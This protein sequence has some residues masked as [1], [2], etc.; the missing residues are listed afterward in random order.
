[1]FFNLAW[2]NSK[3]NR[4]ENLIYFL[5]MVTA[6]ATFYIVL[7]LGSQDVM[8]FLE[9]I[10]SDAVNRL[11]TML[12]PTVYLFS[13]LFVFFLVIFA[14]KYQ[15][16]CR[17]RELGLYLMFG[18]T[19]RHLF[20]Q[21]MAEGLITSLLALLGGLICG[22]FLS[23]VI[24]LATARLVGRGIIAHQSSF[25]VSAVLL[26][27]LGFLMI[28]VVALFILCGKLFNKEIHQ[29]LYGEM[30]KKQQVGKMSG[31]LFSLILGAVVL[32]LAYWVILKY[33]MV[34]GG[35]MII[36]AVILGI[37]GTMLFIRGLA[38]LLS[39]AAASVKRNTTH[40]LYIFTLRQLHENIVHKYIS[41]G[42]ASILI[43][44]T[45]MLIADGSTRI[46]SYGNQM[47]RGSSVYDFTVTGNE[48]TVEKYLSG[49]QMQPYV[50]DLSRM[51]T[52]TM[53][54][55]ASVDANS[56]IDWSG[57]REQ[58]VLNLPP[59]VEDPAT[60]GSASYE[61]SSNQ[62]AA[63]N[64]LG[65]IVVVEDDVYMR[66][67]L[68]DVLKKAGYDAVPLLNFENAVSQIMAL[69][70]DLI[71]LDI[72]LPFHSGFEVCKEIKAKRLGTV[73]ILTARDKLQDELHAL[74]LGAD[75]YLTKPC[76]TE[77]LL[78]RIKNL[79]RRKEEQMQQGLLNGGGFLLD[80]NTFTLYAGKKSYVLPQNEGKILL[81][82][83]K[84]S[85]NLV[86]KSDL[87][88]V[89]WGTAEFIDENALQVN[90]TRLRKTLR[91]VGL[92]DRIE[93]VRGQGYRLKERVEI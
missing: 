10:E 77:R 35:M 43:M 37:V 81:T 88:H 40:G 31:N 11:L 73:L 86:S 48:A 36:V 90:F 2:R 45:I 27:T 4:S 87:F 82:L 21:I 28:Q 55:P 38:G 18:M 66:E 58:V 50:A 80:P 78:A 84:S 49:K 16:E 23:E 8:R 92:G 20:I 72:N 5:T 14:N 68:I 53:K 32:A 39:A 83:L 61:F 26:T 29:L 24:S 19:K 79:L 71:L 76:N 17:S 41:I 46:M 63:L 51:E 3:R 74:G 70:P 67:E 57:L 13:L 12:M 9:E 93:T 42:V 91:E 56:F 47:T 1:M 65:C 54:R 85:P 25:S 34:A 44:L 64:L 7:S 6:V 52:G 62:P 89:L 75:D 33:F 69:S 15:L 59:E 60:Q 22:G 30:A